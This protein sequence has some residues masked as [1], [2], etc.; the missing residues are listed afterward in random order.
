MT[1][2]GALVD[3]DEGALVGPDKDLIHPTDT[4]R[5][6]EL[7]KLESLGNLRSKTQ[8]LTCLIGWSSAVTRLLATLQCESIEHMSSLE[9]ENRRRIGVPERTTVSE[10][11]F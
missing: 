6:P 3:P 7:A 1:R 5:T 2:E 9:R 10:R 11:V 8:C 4:K